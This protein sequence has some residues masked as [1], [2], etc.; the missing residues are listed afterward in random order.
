MMLAGDFET[1]I[2]GDTA[3]PG[4]RFAVY[5]NNIA[6]SL[7]GALAVRYPVVA[8]L[9]GRDF[10]AA[11]AGDFARDN[12][13]VSPVFAAYGDGFPDFVEAYAPAVSV[14]YLADVARLEA[15]WWRAYHA[16]DVAPLA[17]DA[18]VPARAEDLIGWRFEF[19]PS[20]AIVRSRWPVVAIW[21]AHLGDGDLRH[22]DLARGETA[23][24]ARPGLDVRV[25]AVSLIDAFFLTLLIEGATLGQ[26]LA[27][28]Q[29]AHPQFDPTAALRTLV[30]ARTVSAIR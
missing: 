22:I 14:A 11:M 6:A 9:T 25:E 2:A 28:T 5:R 19:L 30:A 24:V 7:I 17:A 16:A 3:L 29:D 18:F 4:R 26:A 8:R 15:A 12:R 23:L 27:Q 21:T 13:P 20:V 10:F 1:A